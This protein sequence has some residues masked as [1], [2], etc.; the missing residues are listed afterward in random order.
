[1]QFKP[2]TMSPITVGQSATASRIVVDVPADFPIPAVTHVEQQ[3]FSDSF[4]ITGVM[5]ATPSLDSSTNDNLKPLLDFAPWFVLD[6]NVTLA[7]PSFFVQGTYEA[8]GPTETRSI[9]FNVEFQP[10]TSLTFAQHT[11]VKGGAGFNNGFL[12]SLVSDMVVRYQAVNPLIFDEQVDGVQFRASFTSNNFP[13]Q[14][15]KGIHFPEPGS[16]T[17]LVGAGLVLAGTTR[18]RTERPGSEGRRRRSDGRDQVHHGPGDC[19]RAAL[20]Y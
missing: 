6:N 5:A 7:L 18:R 3:L 14:L 9:P 17:L 1:M 19:G 4:K 11:G 10:V 12:F 20:R 13:V 2:Y 16:M 8:K 15:L